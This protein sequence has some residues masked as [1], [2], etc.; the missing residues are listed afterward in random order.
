VAFGPLAP[1]RHVEGVGA[2]EHQVVAP[3]GIVEGQLLGDRT[4][5]RVAKHVRGVDGETVEQACQIRQVTISPCTSSRG[6]PDPR[7]VKW[8]RSE[9][10]ELMSVVEFQLAHSA[11]PLAVK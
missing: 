3:P 2:D 5:M 4:S 1:R 8:M 9:G 7:S 11:R 6:S 10:V